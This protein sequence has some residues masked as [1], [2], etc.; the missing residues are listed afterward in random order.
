MLTIGS[1]FSGIG[2]LEKGLEDAGL[3]PVLW[4]V[5]ISEFCRRVLTKHWP[6]VERFDDVREVGAAQLVPVDI[7]CGGF[8]CTDISSAGKGAGLAGERSGLW[9]EFARIVGELRPRWVVVENVAGGAPWVDLVRDDLAGRGY[10][11]L[12]VPLSAEDVGAPHRRSRVFVVA[13][14]ALCTGLQG[15]ECTV[16]PGRPEPADSP[17]TKGTAP[18]PDVRRV[19]HGVPTR[20]DRRMRNS[21]IKALGNAVVP[22]CAEVIGWVVRELERGRGLG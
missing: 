16:T 19:V 8:P 7:I 20:M 11:T 5:E 3:G 2:G 6:S 12:P 9:F 14:N 18:E 22:Q 10:E 1:L 4:Q 13:T 21:R 15:A 17:W